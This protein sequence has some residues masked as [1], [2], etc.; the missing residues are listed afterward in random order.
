MKH[1]T[2]FK[3]LSVMLVLLIV[4]AAIGCGKKEAQEAT[5]TPTATPTATVPAEP[6]GETGTLSS[7]T[8][9]VEVQRQGV[10]AWIAATSGMKIGTGDSLKT[11]SDGYT[12]ITFFDGSVMEVEADSEISAE[13]LSVASGGSTTVRISQVLGNTLNR[14]ENLVDSSSTY[15]VETPA[16]SAVVRGTIYRMFVGPYGAI[17]RACCFTMDEEDEE[18][19]SVAFTGGGVTVNIPENM[20]A[21]A[22]EGGIPGSPFYPD[23]NND[24]LQFATG[25]GGGE[26][27]CPPGCYPIEE[28]GSGDGEVAQ[29]TLD[30]SEF[31]CTCPEGCY[32]LPPT[33][34][35]DGEHC[36]GINGDCC[37][38][39]ICVGETCR[40]Q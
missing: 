18:E 16:G 24:P 21:C 14:V 30:T 4:A 22:V 17:T 37:S 5:P 13:E 12:L 39:Y 28:D 19:H 36:G 9:D 31:I 32:C 25:D 34:A 35:G 1:V 27:S 23:P 38:P 3:W 20:A 8:G 29:F 10:G 2:V 40:L 33:C 26:S 15:D 6:T 11:G 7:V